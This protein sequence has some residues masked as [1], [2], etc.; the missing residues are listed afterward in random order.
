MVALFSNGLS[1]FCVNFGATKEKNT[2]VSVRRRTIVPITHIM[3]TS[4]II[5]FL[6]VRHWLLE[7]PSCGL[8]WLWVSHSGG[9][10]WNMA[11][12]VLG[13]A[14]GA[15][16]S[17]GS[18]VWDFCRLTSHP[19]TRPDKRLLSHSPHFF[20]QRH[21]SQ[22]YHHRLSITMILSDI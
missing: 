12:K 11:A 19:S 17:F 1:L 8:H 21:H 5:D 13:V 20:R 15:F 2:R 18:V 14:G 6:P 9:T 22:K 4:S 3:F 10:D 7:P 16:W